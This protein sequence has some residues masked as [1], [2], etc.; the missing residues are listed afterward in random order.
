MFWFGLFSI[1]PTTTLLHQ[2]R[3][4]PEMFCILLN[5][6]VK[7]TASLPISPPKDNSLATDLNDTM[8]VHIF[9]PKCLYSYF[10]GTSKAVLVLFSVTQ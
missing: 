8:S 4:M 10:I 6:Q 1:S 7:I 5:A 9:L 3:K 2:T